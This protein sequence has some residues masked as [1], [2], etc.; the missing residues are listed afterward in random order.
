M[1]NGTPYTTVN[2]ADAGDALEYRITYRNETAVA[3][4]DVL[5]SDAVPAFT[6]FQDAWCLSTP[7]TGLSGCNVETTPS[8]N[9]GSGTIAW[10][11][12]DA[13]TSPRGLMP[14]AEGA[15]SFCVAV[16]N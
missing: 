5:I 2:E 15:V 7:T 12:V 10:R 9:A 14:A 4:T 11:L 16:E 13:A 8:Q 1:G 6:L 3:V